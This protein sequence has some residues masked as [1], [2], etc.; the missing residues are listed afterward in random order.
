MIRHVKRTI[1]FFEDFAGIVACPQ[2]RTYFPN[3]PQKSQS[4]ILFDNLVWLLKYRNLNRYYYL[5]GLDVQGS[6]Q[7]HYMH[8]KNFYRLRD[9]INSQGNIGK[10]RANYI[11]LLRDKF[12]FGQMLAAAGFNTPAVLAL[13]DRQSIHWLDKASA[14]PLE[15]ITERDCDCFVKPILGEMAH[16][17]YPLKVEKGRLYISEQQ[18]DI[19]KLRGAIDGK[20]ILQRRVIQHER[21]NSLYPSSINTLRIVTALN[22]TG[23]KPLSAILRVGSGNRPYDNWGAGGI[24]VGID[25]S[26]GTLKKYGFF[27]PDFG[28]VTTAHPD[29]G[30]VFDGFEVPF[31]EQCVE[32][33]KKMHKFFYGIHSIGWDFAVTPEGPVCLEGNDNW[34]LP[35]MQIFDNSVIEKYFATLET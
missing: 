11:C 32:D 28:K 33:A 16:G 22:C 25:M 23:A 20:S 5:Y 21:L 6:Q 31:F 26:S 17:V 9:R 30:K 29:T 24:A 2:S 14:G 34:G 35:M 1:G 18:V 4:H 19:E 13:C 27:R 7:N 12:V 10:Y 3:E 8:A 15:G